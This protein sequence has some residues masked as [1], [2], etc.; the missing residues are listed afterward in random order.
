MLIA[1]SGGALFFLSRAGSFEVYLPIKSAAQVAPIDPNADAPPQH[2]LANPPKVIKAIYLTSWSGG[3][4]KKMASVMRLVKETEIN[5]VV[6]DIKD[7]SGIV[8]Y[9]AD[10]PEVKK[11]GAA[12]ARIPKINQF[13]KQLHDAGAYVIGR[14]AV[15]EDQTLPI[16]RPELALRSKKT[17]NMWKNYRGLYW[18]DTASKDVWD[19]NI[20]IAKDLLQRGFDEVNF[21]YIRFPSDGE[22]SDIQYPVWDMKTPRKEIVRQFFAYLREQLGEAKLSADLFGM[23]TTNHDDLNIGQVLEG[24]LPYFDYIAPMV[25]PSHYITGF[26]GYKNPAAAPYEVVRYSMDEGLKRLNAMIALAEAVPAAETT[27]TEENKAPL[28]PIGAAQGKPRGVFRPWLQSFDLG[29]IYDAEK[30]RAQMRAAADA[31]RGCA[32]TAPP[33]KPDA[34]VCDDTVHEDAFGG[35]MNGWMLWN[36]ASNYNREALKNK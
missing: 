23:V 3:S 14:I 1:A 19:Y 16:A 32:K 26:I 2:P 25:Y 28:K 36:P 12:E 4:A 5:A 29:A 35:V 13:V 34:L 6:V 21:D 9:K 31:A 11:A 24:A 7:F 18:L 33:E 17:G 30:I 20:A 22:L 10:I 8:S 27:I 15:F